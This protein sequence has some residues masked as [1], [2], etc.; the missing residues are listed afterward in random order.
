MAMK[1]A[2]ASCMDADRTPDQP[3]WDKI[4]K[5]EPEIL[6]L[7][8]DLIYM[9]WALDAISK[10]SSL[11]EM[12]EQQPN[13]LARFEQLMYTRYAQQWNNEGFQRL[14]RHVVSRPDAL[15]VTRDDHDFAWNRSH[16]GGKGDGY[17]FVEKEV[18]VISDRLFHQFVE[19]LHH[20]D[21]HGGAYPPLSQAAAAARYVPPSTVGGAVQSMLLDQRSF[22][23]RIDETPASL[24][25]AAQAEALYAAV[26]AHRG[27]FIVAGSSPM[28]YGRKGQGWRSKPDPKT[29]DRHE[30]REYAEFIAHARAQGERPI[31]YLAG[32]IHRNSYGGAVESGSS[33]IQVVSSGAAQPA[34]PFYSDEH[35][36]L[37][38]L[39]VDEHAM[40]GEVQIDLYHRKDKPRQTVVLS[41]SEGRWDDPPAGEC[42]EP[43]DAEFY[44]S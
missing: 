16:A 44:P 36:G 10:E 31:L 7:L 3:V 25:G 18:A 21:S 43:D 11:R 17:R 4:R 1:I 28:R 19:K 23:T 32:D 8:G 37:V 9:D 6:M 15:F 14:I 30:Y 41:L 20:P 24:L 42:A 29:G 2:F 39:T 34:L 12:I 27:L 33:I 35:F 38:T 40:N 13:G 5:K 26:A 22:R